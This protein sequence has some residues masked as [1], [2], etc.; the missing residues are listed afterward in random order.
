MR[1]VSSHTFRGKRYNVRR[2]K[3]L[4]GCYGD[5]DHPKVKGKE[6]RLV[7]GL[8]P[9][10]TLEIE[11]HEGLHPCF[12]DMSEEA[13]EESAKDLCKWLWRLGYRKIQ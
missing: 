4:K 8:S 9:Q 5:V 2:V 3:K 1:K 11:L 12:W 13:I 10:R 7:T 6:I